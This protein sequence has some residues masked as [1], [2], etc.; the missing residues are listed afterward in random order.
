MSPLAPGELPST[1]RGAAIFS[2]ACENDSSAT[3]LKNEVGNKQ[4]TPRSGARCFR[5]GGYQE[6]SAQIY[7]NFQKSL[8]SAESFLF[9]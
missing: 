5:W 9:F 7:V 6:F 8:F 4:N 2:Y 1:Y 3:K